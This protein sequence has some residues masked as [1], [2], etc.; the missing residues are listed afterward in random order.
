LLWSIFLVNIAGFAA[1]PT[2][3]LIYGLVAR[4]NLAKVTQDKRC[5][6]CHERVSIKDDRCCSCG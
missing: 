2:T 3:F 4:S 1:M 6:K 5:S